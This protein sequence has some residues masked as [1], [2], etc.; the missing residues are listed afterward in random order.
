MNVYAYMLACIYEYIHLGM[1]VGRHTW[2]YV[3]VC[4]HAWLNVYMYACV[5]ACIWSLYSS[6][7]VC[8]LYD[9][10]IANMIYRAITLK[11][12]IDQNFCI[13]VPI[14]Q[15]NSI[16]YFICYC[17]ICTICFFPAKKGPVTVA[18]IFSA[19]NDNVTVVHLYSCQMWSSDEVAWL[20][21]KMQDLLWS[22]E[23]FYI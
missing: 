16:G 19:E 22:L 1:Y 18:H 20:F 5:H 15:K 8:Q 6:I 17:Y 9:Y 21:S 4:M 11:G 7:I 13:H 2:V 10:Q 12:Y 23:F 3:Y 14:P